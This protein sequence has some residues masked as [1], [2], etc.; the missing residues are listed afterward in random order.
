M[1]YLLLAI[2]LIATVVVGIL[3]MNQRKAID[4]I[5]GDGQPKPE[6]TREWLLEHTEIEGL[7][8]IYLVL[9]IIGGLYSTAAECAAFGTPL[10]AVVHV[11]LILLTIITAIAFV[12][13]DRDAVFLAKAYLIICLAL[14]LLSL[15]AVEVSTIVGIFFCI[16][17]YLFLIF[18][19]NVN[20]VCPVEYRKTSVRGWVLI[21]L[22]AV[23]FFIFAFML[24]S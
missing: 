8:K 15:F 2:V 12:R 11:P 24:F 5:L 16:L 22:F 17:W 20:D 10:W 23:T 6:V 19:E 9:I 14:N 21:G 3:D 18:S 1:I 7:L 13:R 4:K